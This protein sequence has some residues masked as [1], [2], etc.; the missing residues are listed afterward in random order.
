M[1]SLR[2]KLYYI[3]VLLQVIIINCKLRFVFE[4]FRHGAR[5]PWPQIINN[6]DM[7]G[8]YWNGR[9]E[10]T[11]IGIRQHYLLGKRNRDRY[12]DLLNM[13]YSSSEVF[14]EST[15]TNRT[16]MSAYSQLQGLF[17]LSYGPSI[18]EANIDRAVPPVLDYDFTKDKK[19]LKSASLPNQAQVIPIHVMENYAPERG[20]CDGMRTAYNE[21]LNKDVI[22]RAVTDFQEKFGQEI[23]NITTID[24]FPQI[25]DFCDIFYTDYFHS[26]QLKIFNNMPIDL[27]KLNDTCTDILYL[28]LFEADLGETNLGLISMTSTFKTIIDYMSNRINND[29]D[30][31]GYSSSAPKMFMIS[32][33]DT[34]LASIQS[35]L[36]STFPTRFSNYTYPPFASSMYFELYSND[37]QDLQEDN[38]YVLSWFNS[39][40]LFNITFQE[41]K[42]EVEKD[43]INQ[44]EINRFC[45]LEIVKNL[46]LLDVALTCITV[47]LIMFIV[48]YFIYRCMLRRKMMKNFNQMKSDFEIP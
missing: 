25:H 13:T 46:T 31:I 36:K 30:N 23:S 8:E 15:N 2:H 17:P 42:Q 16:I 18:T 7:L 45:G 38:Y 5:A 4:I 19:F 33:H 22:K 39:H 34:N 26:R 35:F 27:S 6:T 3:V 32:G 20:T 48:G 40:L 28:G 44:N 29:K 9:A 12:K 47:V 10:L 37:G 1:L 21:N 24:T 43:S 11:E 14:I 41:F